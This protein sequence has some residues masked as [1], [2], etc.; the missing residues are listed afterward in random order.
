MIGSIDIDAGMLGQQHREGLIIFKPA[1][2]PEVRK[3]FE[4]NYNVLAPTLIASPTNMNVFYKGVDNPLTI[5]VPGFQADDISVSIDNGT[6]T[7]VANGNYNVRVSKGSESKITASVRLPD[8]GTKQVGPVKFRLKSVPKPIARFAGKTSMDNSVKRGE[9]R[10]AQGLM[11][12]MVQFDFPVNFTVQSF[13]VGMTYKGQYIEESSN[14]N[15]ISSKQKEILE[16]LKT[17]QKIDIMNIRVKGPNGES[18]K[19]NSLTLRVGK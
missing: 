11:V 2:L 9:I 13:D 3:N 1:G 16:K 6:L 5:G 17:G 8:G 18:I 15:R 7:K 4:L 19:L 10:A 14:R 12:E